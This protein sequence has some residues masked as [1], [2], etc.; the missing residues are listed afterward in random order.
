MLERRQNEME[1]ELARSFGLHSEYD[2]G[3]FARASG[4]LV[5]LQR[6]TRAWIDRRRR[7]AYILLRRV[8]PI[9]LA[10]SIVQGSRLNLPFGSAVLGPR[11]R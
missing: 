6:A 4:R 9:E 7:Q 3:L 5:Y 10:G 1:V 11:P 8:L 2:R